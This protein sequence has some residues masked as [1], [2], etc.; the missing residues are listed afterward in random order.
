MNVPEKVTGST[1]RNAEE[2]DIW[3]YLQEVCANHAGRRKTG[4]DSEESVVWPSESAPKGFYLLYTCSGIASFLQSRGLVFAYALAVEAKC[5]RWV[6]VTAPTRG[7]CGIVPAV[8]IICKKPGVQRHTHTSCPCYSWTDRKHREDQ[9]FHFGSGSWM[10]GRG[11]CSMFHGIS[12][13][14]PIV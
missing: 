5:V 14:Q 1:S 12:R 9:R 11:R 13:S 6:I 10:L 8:L 7:S 3:D 2:S 4:I